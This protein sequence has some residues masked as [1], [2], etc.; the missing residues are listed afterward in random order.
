M[1]KAYEDVFAWSH[2]D[3]KGVDPKYG[4]HRIDLVEGAIPIRQKQYRLN[5]KYFVAIKD[6]IDKF[7]RAGFIYHILS[8]EWVSPIVIVAK[9]PGPDGKPK[10]RVCQDF[11]KLNEA[12]QKDHYPLPFIDTVLDLVAGH[13][14][15]SFL[16]RYASYTK[17]RLDQKTNSRPLSSQI[18]EPLPSEG[19]LLGYAM[20]QEYS[21]G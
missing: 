19:C 14:L 18:G 5:P 10:I 7:T 21:K 13:R 1:L 4:Q 11:P 8:S 15:Y 3:L 9:K 12:T 2:E 16:D 20:D 17:S 6:E